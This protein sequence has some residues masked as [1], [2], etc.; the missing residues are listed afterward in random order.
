[1]PA[2]WPPPSSAPSLAAR[3]LLWPAMILFGA[4]AGAAWALLAAFLRTRFKVD[5]VVTTLLLNFVLLYGMSALLER[6]VEEPAQRLSHLAA[7]PGR[8]RIPIL[9]PAPSSCISACCW[10]CS[11]FPSSGSS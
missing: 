7:D 9:S 2:P 5:D 10:R 1:M 3:P 6:A 8:S 11:P 4:L